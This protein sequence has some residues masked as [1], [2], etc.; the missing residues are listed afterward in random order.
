MLVYAKLITLLMLNQQRSC[1]SVVRTP[2]RVSFQWTLLVM[3][4]RQNDES[5]GVRSSEGR[6]LVVVETPEGLSN[7]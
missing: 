6:P 1:P 7:W 4:E 2:E 3:F 5:A